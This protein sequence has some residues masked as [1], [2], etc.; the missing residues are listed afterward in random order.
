MS[1]QRYPHLREDEQKVW[2]AFLLLHG[3]EWDTFDYDV[4]VG[5]GHP[6]DPTLADFTKRMVAAVSK[7]RIDAVG[8]KDG[9][10][11]IFEIT[12]RAGGT[13]FGRLPFYKDLFKETFPN[14]P[15]PAVAYVTSWIT[16]DQSRYL[17][18]AGVR[19]YVVGAPLPGP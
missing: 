15:E 12:P 18:R 11:T 13:T 16:A 7:P 17:E 8:W 3:T 14:V 6:V 1:P 4:R 10:P 5:S 9:R 19:V 2:D